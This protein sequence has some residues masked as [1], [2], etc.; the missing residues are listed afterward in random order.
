MASSNGHS[1]V[2]QSIDLS[3][4]LLTPRDVADLLALPPSTV[5]ELA[6]TGR[7]PC[8]RIGRAVRFDQHALEA[9]IARH[10]RAQI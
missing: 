6:R 7:L 2:S 9:Y 10:C 1:D 3:R 8:L 5:Y 4:R